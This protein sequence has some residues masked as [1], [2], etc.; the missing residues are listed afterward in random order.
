[1]S[2]SAVVVGATGFIGSALV[3]EL[4]ARGYSVRGTSR[5]PGGD[6]LIR[7]RG[8]TPVRADMMS[9][10]SLRRGFDGCEVIFHAG[11][12]N[13]LCARDPG[14][15]Y[16]VN[17][18]GSV[19]VMEAAGAVG[20]R[21]V[22]YTS[23]AATI[24]E[25]AGTVA[26][27]STPHRGWF[28][29]HYERSKF[30]A[31]RR[32]LELGKE[33]GVEVM[34]LNPS[35]VQGPGRTRGTARFLLR[36][37]QGRLRWLVDTRVSVLDIQDCVAAHML[38][39]TQGQMGTRHLLNGATLTVLEL[40]DLA[41]EVSGRRPRVRMVPPWMALAGG[42]LAEAGARL[43]RRRPPVCREMV[44]TLLHGHAYDG[45]RAAAELGFVYT[46]LPEFVRRTFSWYR[47]QGLID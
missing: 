14:R 2:G 28:L 15:L 12:M 17:V 20:V 11:G 37:A 24:G 36:Y 39:A 8:G 4:A 41:S 25:A 18:R 1:M 26:T 16:E 40:M 31:E 13:T 43:V 6:D 44:R 27:E 9:P 42:G 23:S 46:P 3:A 22:V 45:S 29:S 32:V 30:L 5:T 35:S 34:C 19:N 33:M 7:S 38:S 21:R 10:P 47:E